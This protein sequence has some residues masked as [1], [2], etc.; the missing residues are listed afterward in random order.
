MPRIAKIAIT[1]PE[2][3]GKTMISE[4]LANHYRTVWVPEFARYY[5]KKIDRPYNYDDILEIATSQQKSEMALKK[6]ANRILFSDTE[7]L[8]TKIWCEVKYQKCH[9]RIIQ[10][11]EKQDYDLYL[12]MNTDIPWVDD[13]MRE[14][15]G[16]R[17]W[18]FLLYKNELEK[19]RF[20]FRIVTGTGN[21]RLK[22]AIKFVDELVI[23]RKT[24]I[25]TLAPK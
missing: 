11:I 16:L 18:L 24:K 8:V 1:G 25:Q 12:L 22:N 15:P 19:Y 17:D 2:S 13:P 20:N 4:E 3:T 7:L 10:N 9:P 21:D 6:I 5:L 14:H 23:S